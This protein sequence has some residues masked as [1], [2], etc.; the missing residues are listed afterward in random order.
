MWI[1]V[2]GYRKRREHHFSKVSPVAKYQHQTDKPLSHMF[3]NLHKDFS[4]GEVAYHE[5]TLQ[6]QQQQLKSLENIF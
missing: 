4:N 6:Q 5:L 3:K 1:K 2:V